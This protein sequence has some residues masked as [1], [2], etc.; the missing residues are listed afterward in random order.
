MSSL[1]YDDAASQSI[2][3]SPRALFD[4]EP[5]EVR[6]LHDQVVAAAGLLIRDSRPPAPE[7]EIPGPRFDND[8]FEPADTVRSPSEIEEPG[9]A[10]WKSLSLPPALIPPL[11]DDDDDSVGLMAMAKLGFAV[12]LAAGVAYVVTSMV[13]LPGSSPSMAHDT[14]TVLSELTQISTAQ[15]GV[16]KN[17]IASI[18]AATILAAAQ[19][20]L[21]SGTRQANLDTDASKTAPA[22]VVAPPTS[23][24]TAEPTVPV[25]PAPP[26]AAVVAP[27]AAAEVTP[28]AP[29]SP[30][31]HVAASLPRDEVVA[32]MKRGRDLL[33]AGDIASARLILT[34]LA[35][36]GEAEASLLLAGTFDPVQ[37]ARL[38]VLGVRPDLEKAREWYAK[39]AEQRSPKPDRHLQQSASR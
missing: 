18:P 19:A 22:A 20:N 8:E 34:R 6:R 24:A 15:A 26:P 32:L 27:Q 29:P 28:P 36:N 39:A 31:T 2:S 10:L 12:G 1:A 17:D 23:A 5:E 25:E 30:P 16:Q 7:I 9:R 37:L 4:H 33:A 35:D 21:D 13:Q 11:P 38:H 3:A 14:T